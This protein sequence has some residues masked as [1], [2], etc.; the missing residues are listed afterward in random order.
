MPYFK[1]FTILS[2]LFVCLSPSVIVAQ[3]SETQQT[4]EQQKEEVEREQ[5][6]IE[7]FPRKQIPLRNRKIRVRDILLGQPRFYYRPADSNEKFES[8]GLMGKKLK[9]YFENDP[10][11]MSYFK[12]YRRAT[13]AKSVS[14]LGI[15][16]GYAGVIIGAYSSLFGG[17][18]GREIMTISG[19]GLGASIGLS[20][21]FGSAQK[22]SMTNAAAVYNGNFYR[23]TQGL[24]MEQKTIE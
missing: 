3:E 6:Y 20:F 17:R 7:V 5:T 21:V 2:L 9:P 14:V 16:I 4:E 13:L 8:I 19:I 1:Y 23:E 11:A 22:N 12:K 24:P 15:Y 10:L 18:N